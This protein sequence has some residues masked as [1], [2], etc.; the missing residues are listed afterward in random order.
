MSDAAQDLPTVQLRVISS[1]SLIAAEDWDACANPEGAV[2]NPFLRH[3]YLT[4]LEESGSA[5]A[6]TGWQGQ[7]LID[8]ECDIKTFTIIHKQSYCHNENFYLNK[9]NV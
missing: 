1:L 7:H 6:E 2:Y 4:A 9:K 5:T 8:Q 3:A